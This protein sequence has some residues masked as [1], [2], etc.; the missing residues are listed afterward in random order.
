VLG[1]TRLHVLHTRHPFRSRPHPAPRFPGIDDSL[2]TSRLAYTARARSRTRTS[3]I[4][5]G[6]SSWSSTG[7]LVPCSRSSNLR[8]LVLAHP[9][10]RCAELSPS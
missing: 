2:S 8:F 9:W 1:T 10:D 3:S 4:Q 6:S 5:D 7:P